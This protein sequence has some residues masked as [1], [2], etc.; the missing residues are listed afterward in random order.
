MG[1]S[2]NK[3]PHISLYITLA[4]RMHY[5]GEAVEGVVHVDCKAQRPYTSLYIKLHG[6]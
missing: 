6:C 4:K 3:D 5:A 1:S 2:Q